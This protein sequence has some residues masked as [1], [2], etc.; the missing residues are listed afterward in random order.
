MF[1]IDK[2]FVS[3]FLIKTIKDN[4]FNIVSTKEAKGL[5]NDDSIN[6]VSEQAAIKLFKESQ[7]FGTKTPI[8]T[9]SENALTWITNNFRGSKLSN[10]YNYLKIKLNLES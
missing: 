5:I 2:P 3:D 6:W 9:N 7:G 8:Y 1:L 4:N 10:Q